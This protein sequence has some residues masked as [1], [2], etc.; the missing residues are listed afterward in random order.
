[1]FRVLVVCSGNICRSPM[2]EVV[3]RN[4]AEVAG[5]ALLVDSAG[6]GGWHAGE[7]IDARAA[8]ALGEAG[9]PTTG[10]VARQVQ[11]GW[12][13]ERDLVLAADRVNLRELAPLARRVGRQAPIR[14][15]GEFAGGGAGDVPDIP[16]PY[17]GGPDDF[18]ACL[19]LI[20]RCCAGVVAE[21]AAGPARR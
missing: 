10:H 17:Y 11:P 16:D 8:A 14:L 5:I 7:T 18:A 2:A 6:T 13:A 3:L 4:R 20:E 15:L 12:L 19:A 21:L 9:Y 1:M